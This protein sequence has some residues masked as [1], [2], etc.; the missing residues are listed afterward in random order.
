MYMLPFISVQN[1]NNSDFPILYYYFMHTQH[2][3]FYIH[4]CIYT[5]ICKCGQIINNGIFL[6]LKIRNLLRKITILVFH[7]LTLF[8]RW[9]YKTDINKLKLQQESF[10]GCTKA[11][12]SF[13]PFVHPIRLVNLPP[14]CRMDRTKSVTRWMPLIG[15]VGKGVKRNEHP[16]TGAKWNKPKCIPAGDVTVGAG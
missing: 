9:Q 12:T 2:T 11:P 1:W 13:S 5:F 16:P 6:K 14:L 7:K 4:I 8:V 10:L 3:Y 15:R